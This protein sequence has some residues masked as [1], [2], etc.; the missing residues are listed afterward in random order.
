MD[1]RLRGV[2]T[3]NLKNITV[4]FPRYKFIVVTGLAAPGK[5]P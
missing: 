1:I 2:R 4:S 5:A 3:H